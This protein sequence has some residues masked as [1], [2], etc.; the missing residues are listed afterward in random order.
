MNETD[1]KGLLKQLETL[2]KEKP[3]Y[4]KLPGGAGYRNGYA[5]GVKHAL[6]RFKEYRDRLLKKDKQ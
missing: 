5:D 6:G 1:I 4:D 3:N 2:L